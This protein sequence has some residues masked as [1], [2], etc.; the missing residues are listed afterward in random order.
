MDQGRQFGILDPP[1]DLLRVGHPLDQL[2]RRWQIEQQMSKDFLR[3]FDKEFTLFV[4]GRLE[5]RSR[6]RARFRPP[7][8][9]FGRPPVGT[10]AV[11]RIEHNIA[12]ASGDKTVR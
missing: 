10:S 7:N 5:K 6:N 8:Q 9:F 2:L 1:V 11:K 3:T 12:T 4:V